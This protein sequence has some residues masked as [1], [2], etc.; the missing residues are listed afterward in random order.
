MEILNYSTSFLWDVMLVFKKLKQ[1][2]LFVLIYLLHMCN[3]KFSFKIGVSVIIQERKLEITTHVKPSGSP[4]V[5]DNEK[6]ALAIKNSC[7]KAQGYR[8]YKSKTP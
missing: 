5:S 8:V 3:T 2:Y 1:T 4:L 6:Q 7:P